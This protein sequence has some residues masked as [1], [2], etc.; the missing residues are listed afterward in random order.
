MKTLSSGAG[1]LVIDHTD[2][3][4]LSEK[5]QIS[6]PPGALVAPAGQLAEGDIKHC[7]HCQRAVLLNP[8]RVRNRAVCPKCYHYICDGCEA[9]RVKTGVCIPFKQQLDRAMEIATKFVGQLD[10]PE[11]AKMNDIG[12]LTKSNEPRIIVP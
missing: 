3:P 7:S 2:S 10:H 9:I 8:G 4:G 5:D 12:E 11:A 6:A 1:Y